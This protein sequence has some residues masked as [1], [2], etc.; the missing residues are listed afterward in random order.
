MYKVYLA[1]P[2]AGLTYEAAQAWREDAS[3]N[4]EGYDL[5]IRCFSPLRGKEFLDDGLIIEMGQYSAHPLSTAAGVTARDGN[6]IRT[7]DVILVNVSNVRRISG[8][9]AWELGVAWALNKIVVMVVSKDDYETGEDGEFVNPYLRHLILS[10]VPYI[11]TSLD[12]AC[13]LTKSILLS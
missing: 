7:A 6:D 1:G 3:E 12:A 11:V 2:I 5:P 9:T 10:Q 13:A 8:G 4:I